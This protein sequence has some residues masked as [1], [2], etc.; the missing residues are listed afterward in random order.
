MPIHDLRCK[1]CHLERQNVFVKD[2]FPPCPNCGG[3]LDWIP[4]V[5]MTDCYGSTK[6]SDILYEDVGVPATYSSRRELEAKMKRLNFEPCG[7]KVGGARN[8]DSYRG[9]SFSFDGNLS[10]ATPRTRSGRGGEK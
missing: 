3:E 7:D 6:T 2:T 8:E 5:P 10:R 4:F 9:T 1:S